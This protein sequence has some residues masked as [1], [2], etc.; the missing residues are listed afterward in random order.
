MR[1][2]IRLKYEHKSYANRLSYFA[3]VPKDEVPR[4]MARD[5]INAL[6]QR[7]QYRL[8]AVICVAKQHPRVFMNKQGIAYSGIS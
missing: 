8:H 7:L 1:L 5:S 6:L 3:P 4:W 2:F